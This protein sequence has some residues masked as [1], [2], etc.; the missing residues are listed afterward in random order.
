MTNANGFYESTQQPPELTPEE[1]QAIAAREAKRAERVAQAAHE[2]EKL[3]RLLELYAR[4]RKDNCSKQEWENVQQKRKEACQKKAKLELEF[5]AALAGDKNLPMVR[6]TLANT[7]DEIVRETERFLVI[8]HDDAQS[9]AL[10]I[11]QTHVFLLEVFEHTPFLMVFSKHP[12]SGKSTLAE[13][14]WE[15][16]ANV[17]FTASLVNA[18]HRKRPSSPVALYW[19]ASSKSRVFSPSPIKP[20]SCQ[21][22]IR[23]GSFLLSASRSRNAS[24]RPPV[25]LCPHRPVSAR[26]PTLLSRVAHADQSLDFD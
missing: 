9:I 4:F 3:R 21:Y 18:A 13:L 12:D 22:L 10:W 14:I 23:F 7:L 16:S 19:S 11:V 1:T 17:R 2:L 20:L 8:D 6:P 25:M 26:R 5:A 24:N 15:L